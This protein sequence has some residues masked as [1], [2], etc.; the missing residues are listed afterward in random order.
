M[1]AV[2]PARR[3]FRNVDLIPAAHVNEGVRQARALDLAEDFKFL[4]IPLVTTAVVPLVGEDV[5]LVL[6]VDDAPGGRANPLRRPETL[7]PS[8]LRG[9]DPRDLLV[10]MFPGDA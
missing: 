7:H 4:S 10:K 1:C 2:G 6:D 3:D 9:L 8:F 5:Y